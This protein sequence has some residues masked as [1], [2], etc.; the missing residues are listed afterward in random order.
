MQTKA[1]GN[2]IIFEIKLICCF[3]LEAMLGKVKINDFGIA[4][5]IFRFFRVLVVL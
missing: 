5:Q 3:S 1:L 2:D 4:K